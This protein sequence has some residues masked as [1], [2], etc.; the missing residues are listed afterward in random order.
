MVI[1]PL[2][3]LVARILIVLNTKNSVS[4][5]GGGESRRIR[6]GKTPLEFLHLLM[7]RPKG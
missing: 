1:I 4:A 2:N 6:G 7:L 5:M 3:L